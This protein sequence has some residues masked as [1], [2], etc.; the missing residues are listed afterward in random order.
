MSLNDNKINKIESQELSFNLLSNNSSNSNRHKYL[1]ENYTI[2]TEIIDNKLSINIEEKSYLDSEIKKYEKLYS[3]EEL[4][5]ISKVFSM[6]DKIEDS[7]N[8]LELN[9]NNFIISLDDKFC[10]LTIKLD[11]KE[12]PKNKISDSIIFK[13]PLTVKDNNIQSNSLNDYKNNQN[14]INNNSKSINIESNQNVNN[15]NSNSLDNNMNIFSLIQNLMSKVNQLTEENKEIKN[16]L[17]VLEKN[18]NELIN[19]IKEN[20]INL[21]KE[22][23]NIDSPST[24]ISNNNKKIEENDNNKNNIDF[25]DF[26]LSQSN[27]KLN[28]LENENSP[29]FFTRIHSRFLKEKTKSKNKDDDIFE[30]DFKQNKMDIENYEEKNKKNFNFKESKNFEESLKEKEKEKQDEEEDNY[31]FT[32]KET[33]NEIYDDMNLFKNNCVKKKVENTNNYFGDKYKMNKN[34]INLDE[35]EE[36]KKEKYNNNIKNKEEDAWSFNKSIKMIGIAYSPKNNS[37]NDHSSFSSNQLNFKKSDNK[38]GKDFLI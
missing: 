16:R 24:N 1:H 10:V 9:D 35:N 38:R 21:L 32:N 29:N 33:E 23:N 11:T 6:F 14:K 13:I 36:E 30:K 26:F 18:N 31:L 34:I 3:Q 37:E 28:N 15:I 27:F 12:L 7:F 19:I 8:I 4:I 2:T 5:E 22:K 25:N 17:N 20:R